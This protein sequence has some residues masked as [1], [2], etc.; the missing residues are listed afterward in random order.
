M[1]HL[2]LLRQTPP[3][4]PGEVVVLPNPNNAACA[5]SAILHANRHA[6]HSITT[7]TSSVSIVFTTSSKNCLPVFL[8]PALPRGLL[9][10]RFSVVGNAESFWSQSSRQAR[11]GS[12]AGGAGAGAGGAGAGAGGAGAGAGAQPLGA[13]GARAQP[14]GAISAMRVPPNA[15][16]KTYVNSFNFGKVIEIE[17]TAEHAKKLLQFPHLL[18]DPHALSL[19]AA[20]IGFVMSFTEAKA[21]ADRVLLDQPTYDRLVQCLYFEMRETIRGY[22]P[23]PTAAQSEPAADYSKPASGGSGVLG[24]SSRQ[25]PVTLGQGANGVSV[26]SSCKRAAPG[27]D[28]DVGGGAAAN[29]AA[30]APANEPP[31]AADLP[32]SRKAM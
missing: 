12:G 21:F 27:D 6:V 7:A 4:F 23:I 17:R 11:A 13:I 24:S 16:L 31:P 3:L 32:V 20:E 18:N 30:V 14:Q 19:K 5:A 1:H 9:R 25:L 8:T 28:G 15:S 22:K 10:R 2:V 29:A 26:I